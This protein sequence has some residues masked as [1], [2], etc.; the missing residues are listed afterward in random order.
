ML[1]DLLQ[2]FK[3]LVFPDNCFLCKKYTHNCNQHYLCSDCLS[4]IELNTPPF[5]LK[6]SRHLTI[7]NDQGFCPTCLKNHYS[8]DAAWSACIYEKPLAD[9]IYAFKYHGKTYFRKTFGELMINFIDSYQIPIQNFDMV[10]PIPLHAV[11]FRE[12]GF[13]QAQLLSQI[14]SDHYGL[15]HQIDILK[16][17]KLT[18]SQTMLEAKQRWTNVND[19]FKINDS[20][21]IAD[22]NILIVD[23]LLTTAA[24]A[25]AASK[26]LKGAGAAYVGI[27]TLAIT[28]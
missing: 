6:C 23:D 17:C 21:K 19:A 25:D 5:C 28:P 9:L 24:T 15:T 18:A 2:G 22:K 10:L 8:F 20:L 13:N 26:A 3:E 7:F 16:R 4:S 11:R 27:L 14:L 1:Q 12:R